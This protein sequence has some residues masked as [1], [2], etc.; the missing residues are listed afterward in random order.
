VAIDDLDGDGNS[1]LAVAN[2][3]SNTISVLLGT[4]TGSF[5]A[6]T[7]LTTGNNPQTAVIADF[8]GDGKPDLATANA[9]SDTVS[10][11][12]NEEVTATKTLTVTNLGPGLGTVASAP[13]GISCGA[14]CSFAFTTGA[15][16]TLTATPATGS[17]FAGWSGSGCSG[18]GSC[19]L[20][21]DNSRSVTATFT[22]VSFGAKTD[23]A[24]GSDPYFVATGDLNGDGNPEN[25]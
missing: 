10:V 3:G 6:K 15:T 8:N 16:A 17:S 2:S 25:V 14:T 7:E 4:G 20:T 18:S 23:F 11:L 19:V 5:G 9:G 24:A 22:P 21:M 13:S 1:D 12:L